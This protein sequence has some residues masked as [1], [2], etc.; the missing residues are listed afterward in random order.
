[1]NMLHNPRLTK[2]SQNLRRKMTKEEKRL[3]YQFLKRL[4]VIVK[5][6]K[7]IGRYIVDFCIDGA[8]IVIEVDGSQHYT[9]NAEVLDNDR[10]RYLKDLGYKVL[11]FTNLEI[12]RQF[13]AV[14]LEIEKQLTE[15]IA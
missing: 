2:V 13:Q 4:P 11:R 12:Q 7:I 5:R 3:W 6:Q 1:M 15:G 10:D 9:E 8:K 14:C